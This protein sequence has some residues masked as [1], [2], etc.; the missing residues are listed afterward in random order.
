MANNS[1]SLLLQ[2]GRVMTGYGCCS[3][4]SSP[5]T[6][7]QFCDDDSRRRGGEED[8]IIVGGCTN[9]E[10]EEFFGYFLLLFSF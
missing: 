4:R 8:G 3:K 2:I 1:S 10:R 6:P 5:A 7:H 9:E